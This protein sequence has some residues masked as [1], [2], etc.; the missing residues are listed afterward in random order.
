MLCPLI[1]TLALVFKLTISTLSINSTCFMFK[2]IKSSFSHLLK[3]EVT[4]SKCR[5]NKIIFDNKTGG[6]DFIVSFVPPPHFLSPIHNTQTANLTSFC[7]CH[8]LSPTFLILQLL[9]F[10]RFITPQLIT[11]S[12]FLTFPYSLPSATSTHLHSIILSSTHFLRG[13]R[14]TLTLFHAFLA[15]PSSPCLSFSLLAM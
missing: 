1:K 12:P 3:H 2:L 6:E 11:P 13:H 7:S 10:I 15:S 9:L 4:S 5:S 8:L 14:D